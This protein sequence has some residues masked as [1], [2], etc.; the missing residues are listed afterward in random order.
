MKTSLRPQEISIT[1]HT[2][3]TSLLLLSS[4]EVQALA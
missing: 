4:M 3:S 1:F 2:L